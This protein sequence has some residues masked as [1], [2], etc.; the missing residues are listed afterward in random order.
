MWLKVVS[1]QNCPFW[2]NYTFQL[3]AA[4]T[5][6]W[7]R[8]TKWSLRVGKERSALLLLLFPPSAVATFPAGYKS[9]TS[10]CLFTYPPVLPRRRVAVQTGRNFSA[11]GVTYCYVCPAPHLQS[12][13][14]GSWCINPNRSP[15]WSAHWGQDDDELRGIYAWAESQEAK[16]E[17]VG[18][19]LNSSNVPCLEFFFDHGQ[20][21][22]ACFKKNATR[23][24]PFLFR[25]HI[26]N[27]DWL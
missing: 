18:K 12:I 8:E 9:G 15:F 27:H 3:G 20:L 24:W 4:C 1:P 21:V 6:D 26:R 22:I 5:D 17:V 14:P 10:R 25:R 11:L 2:F 23:I 19:D 7:P 13:N 16:R